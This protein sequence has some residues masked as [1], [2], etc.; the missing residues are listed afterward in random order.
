[1]SIRKYY[2]Q[3]NPVDTTKV[4]H[5]ERI[6]NSY[7][8]L[9]EA[10][11]KKADIAKRDNKAIL[12]SIIDNTTKIP[13]DEGEVSIQWSDNALK[14]AFDNDDFDTAFPSGKPSF[15]A[16]NGKSLRITQIQKTKMFGGGSGSGGGSSGTRA[17][18]SA[19]CV[20]CQAI[21]NNPKTDFNMLELQAAYNQV[22]VDA[23]WE[24]IEGLTQDWVVSSI[25]VAKGLY[26]ALG[27]NQYSFHRG[28]AFVEMIENLFKNSGQDYF[29]NVNKWTPA[30]IWIVQDTKLSNYDFSGNP[31]LPYINQ[32]LMKAYAARDIMGISLKKT[33]KVKFKQ[34]NYKKPF[35]SPKFTKKTLG[36]RDFFSS[37]DGYIFGADGLEMQFRTFPA[38]QAEIIGKQAKHGKL[39]G[40]SGITSPIGKVLKGAGVTEFPTR[41]SVTDMIKRENDKFFEMFYSE[42]LSAG[43]DAKV[44]LDDFK[45]K[46]GKK[47]SN[48]LESKYL[49]TFM[50]N[51]LSGKE[52]K[53]LELAYRYAKSESEDS[54]VHLKA[55]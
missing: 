33:T 28:S 17:A 9:T 50:F 44:T 29:T 2:R 23:S 53:F 5:V 13:T 26:R 54:C 42:Y 39:S 15:I 3:L 22:K 20:Y 19:Q 43:E 6:Q 37:K 8:E 34:I 35:K 4:S 31:A 45:K 14:V 1:M 55:M 7:S 27:R 24:E 36:K 49:V 46:L 21:W 48:W 32:E 38:F 11:L 41:K 25:S 18:E 52:Q 47:D 30:D 16:S 12:Q 40:D 51:R 10:N